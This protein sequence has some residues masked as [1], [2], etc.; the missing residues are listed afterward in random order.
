MAATQAP[1]TAV[2]ARAFRIPTDTPESDGTLC[3]DATTLVLAEVEA[4]GA[5]G[6]GYTYSDL[7]AATLAN[8]LLG[9]HLLGRDAL[10]TQQRWDGMVAAVRNLGACGIAMMAISAIDVALWDLKGKLLHT[11]L[12][13]LL[14]ASRAAIDVYGSGGFSSYDDAQLQAQLGGWAAQGFRFVKMKVGRDGG[15]DPRRVQV[16]RREIGPDVELFVDANGAYSRDQA[17]AMA[18]AFAAR[19]V[20]WFEEPVAAQDVEGLRQVR[21]R[22]PRGMPLAAGEYGWQR[23]DF[24]RLV[25][26]G[27]VDILQADATRCGGITGFMQ[28]AR[29]CAERRV[30]LSSHCAPSLHVAAC[31]SAPTALH[32]EWF[33]DHVRI[34]QRLFDGAARPT[35]G[36]LAPSREPGLGLVFREPDAKEN[37]L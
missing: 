21:V 26:A 30:P 15:D 4:A 29:L 18:M 36:R 8:G 35:G 20:R 31:C 5:T 7:A 2:R 34:E 9:E 27:A 25:D 19:D 23:C 1:I 10:D 12:A 24:K 28:V 22:L 6:I 14:P 17:V 33:H 13:A 16:A 3:W 11:P 37:A 32:V